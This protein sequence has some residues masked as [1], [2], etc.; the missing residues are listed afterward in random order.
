MTCE[1]KDILQKCFQGYVDSA[2]IEG[3]SCNV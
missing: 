3:K 2:C 1:G